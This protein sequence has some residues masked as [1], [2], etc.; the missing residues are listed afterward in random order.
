MN[1]WQPFA[2]PVATLVLAGAVVFLGFQ[3]G[4]KASATRV[5][6]PSDVSVS[7][8]DMPNVRGGVNV[9]GEVDVS[10]KRR[11]SFNVS[12]CGRRY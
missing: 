10:N 1:K 9:Y 2:Q 8:T 11:S 3:Q 5:V 4:Q 7:I 6:F 12:G